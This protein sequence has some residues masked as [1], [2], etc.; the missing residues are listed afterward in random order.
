MEEIV[1]PPPITDQL[2]AYAPRSK[3]TF[4]RLIAPVFAWL[5]TSRQRD[6]IQAAELELG[7]R[8]RRL[9]DEILAHLSG[10][11]GGPDFIHKDEAWRLTCRHRE[12]VREACARMA[13]GLDGTP[14]FQKQFANWMSA[15]MSK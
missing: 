14:T 4:Q 12:F 8:F 13:K 3:Q 7:L 11:V 10:H 2:A 5:Q 15:N 6:K 1:S 9:E